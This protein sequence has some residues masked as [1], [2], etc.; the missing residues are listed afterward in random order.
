MLINY[1]KDTE[2]AEKVVT[3]IDGEAELYQADITSEK[4]VEQMF[5][6]IKSRH[7]SLDIVINNAG[8]LLEGDSID[9]VDVFRKTFDVNVIGQVIIVKE[10]LK[11]MKKAKLFLYHRSMVLWVAAKEEWLPI[12]RQR[13]QLILI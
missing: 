8:G 12:P 3:E 4:Q 2:A 6:S 1:N 11:M 5:E 10:T 7:D 13:L 9:N